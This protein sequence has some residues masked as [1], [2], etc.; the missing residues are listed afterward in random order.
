MILPYLEHSPKIHA[1]AY[2]APGAVV[3]G[4]VD[5]QE[6]VSI[7]YNSV[8]RGDVDRVSIGRGTNI[9]DGCLLHQNE[10]VPLVIG[11]EVTVGH[12]AILHGCTI[13]D[14]CLIGMGAIILTGAKIGPEALIGAGSV[15][16]EGQEIPPGVLAV[17]SPARVIRSLSDEERSG[18]RESARHY[19]MMAEQHRANAK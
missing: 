19:R 8:V 15:V 1:S 2:I 13:G 18:L 14:G 17:G 16:K 9:Q 5:L 10:G 6:N 4:R 12:G 3:V 7:W 11:E